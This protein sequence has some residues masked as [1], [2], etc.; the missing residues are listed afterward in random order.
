MS[1]RRI[2]IAVDGEPLA[3]RAGDP[4]EGVTVTAIK[5]N[6]LEA[7]LGLAVQAACYSRL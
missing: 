2:L 6:S 3:A 5:A 7:L 1:F 4:S